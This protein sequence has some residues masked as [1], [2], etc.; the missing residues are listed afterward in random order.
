MRRKQIM[1]ANKGKE[2]K[3]E[4]NLRAS[5]FATLRVIKA[6]GKGRCKNQA[7][8][9]RFEDL[10]EE[11]GLMKKYLNEKSVKKGGGCRSS[12]EMISSCLN[13]IKLK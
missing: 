3:A 8:P 4:R 6:G 5:T 1:E 12:L 13:F 9:D 7:T 11:F 2:A 10:A